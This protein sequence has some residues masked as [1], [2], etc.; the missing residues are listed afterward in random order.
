MGLH[1]Y[2]FYDLISRNAV[3]YNNLSAWFEV[4]DQRTLTFAEYKQKVD[5]LACGLQKTG[6]QK[7]DRI[8][9][10]GKNSLE[11]FLLYGAAAA[12]GAIVLPVN[13]RLSAEETVFNLADCEPVFL[14]VDPDYQQM[15]TEAKDLLTSVKEYV[16]LKP[17]GGN[18]SDFDALLEND[19]KFAAPDVATEDGLVIIH[20]AAVAG[21]P[22]GALLSHGNLISANI[23]INLLLNLSA[24]DV[25]L[26]ILPLY[27]VG[28]LFMAT[29][30]FH[31]GALNL[32]MSKFDAGQAVDLIADKKVT[33]MFDFA[34][35]L[36]SILE[37]HE[38]S[39]KDIKTLQHVPGLE[40]PA[41]IE[42]YQELTGGTFYCMYGQTETSAIVTM[43]PYS[44]KPGSAGRPG[45]LADV[46]LVADNDQPV[47]AGETGEIAV[48]GP[49]V[50]KG[51]WNLPEDTEQAFRGGW[52]HT[53]DLGRFDEDG[54]LWYEGRKA[55]KELIK[56]GGENVYPA[57]VEKA[58]LEHSAVE[59]AV[60][61]GVP[62]PKWKEGIKAVCQ[63]KSGRTLEA[64]EL[65]KFV[66]GRIASYKKPQYVEFVTELP[67][68]KEGGPDRARI[69]ELY[70]GEQN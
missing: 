47:S 10:I 70:G 4:D 34:P 50:F 57:E 36:S 44:E 5:Q 67:R 30:G 6:L 62:D 52:H 3:S 37:E 59:N 43:A 32:N 11:Y 19:G 39:G 65:I 38:K 20:T 69:R 68:L 7:G 18:F 55:E 51:Y 26:N 9:I 63:L 40:A 14:F 23:H 24:Y 45:Q 15:I 21:R 54:F 49:M 53:G 17:P 48:K 64:Q 27:H 25:H 2:T 28:G 35:I 12:L 56:P 13:W 42:K 8:G 46:R 58:I 29:A 16:N 66:G 61:F 41:V 33:F 1:D 22:R 60:V 31:A